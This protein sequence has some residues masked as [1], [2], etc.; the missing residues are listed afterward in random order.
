VM[1][2]PY[3]FSPGKRTLSDALTRRCIRLTQMEAGVLKCLHDAA[4]E[5]VPRDLLLRDVWNYK[6]DAR[7]HTVETHI[8]RLRRKIRNVGAALPLIAKTRGGYRLAGRY[9]RDDLVTERLQP[10]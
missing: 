10:A 1:I 7:S 3:V 5:P 8:Y 6:C 2:G 4:G 9:D